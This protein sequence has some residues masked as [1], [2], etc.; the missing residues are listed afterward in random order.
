[1]TNIR[2][3]AAGQQEQRGAITVE[4][5]ATPADQ[6]PAF[7]YNHDGFWR[8]SIPVTDRFDG[9]PIWI[10]L[11]ANAITNYGDDSTILE[12]VAAELLAIAREFGQDAALPD[13]RKLADIKAQDLYTS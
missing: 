5:Y 3:F 2:E 11:H 7:N 1:V 10:R 6:A 8:F 9:Q 13:G 4:R 12:Y